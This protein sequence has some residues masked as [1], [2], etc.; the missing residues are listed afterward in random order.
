VGGAGTIATIDVDVKQMPQLQQLRMVSVSDMGENGH[1]SG[2]PYYS[3]GD[4][5]RDKDDCHWICVRP[6]YSPSGKEDTHWMSFQLNENS[7]IKYYRKSNTLF[8]AY[9]VNLGVQKE[10]MQYL[11]QLLTILADP[12]EYVTWAGKKGIPLGGLGE[13]AMSPQELT[14]LAWLWEI[15]YIWNKIAPE[16]E[17]QGDEE[18]FDFSESFTAPVCFIYEK[19]SV[20][21]TKLSIPC[22]EYNGLFYTGIP[23]YTTKTIDMTK[24]S[25]DYKRY[26]LNYST[27]ITQP[28]TFIVRY[29][30]GF[31]LSSNIIFS[32]KATEAIPGVRT[33]FRYKEHKN[34]LD[35]TGISKSNVRVGNVIAKNGRFYKNADEAKKGGG[36]IAV[37]VYAGEK[38][39][40][41]TGTD[42]RGL[43]ISINNIGKNSLAKFNFIENKTMYDVCTTQI[44]ENEKD[45]FRACLNG[46]QQTQILAQG[47]GK[48]HVHPAAYACINDER[49]ISPL[50]RQENGFSD[51]FLPST[52]QW[53]LMAENLLGMRWNGNQFNKPDSEDLLDFF[54]DNAGIYVHFDT[55]Q[56]LFTSTHRDSE[57]CWSMS[58]YSDEVG[59]SSYQDKIFYQTVVPMMAF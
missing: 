55:Y 12:D 3:F 51:W 58:F 56:N 28:D 4:V 29:K 1:F 53:I 59:F 9:P 21:G 45:R 37:V 20:S 47:C 8:Q 52:G 10:K 23:T 16:L 11:A 50:M 22:V 41:E 48:G 46:L 2:E 33:V 49:L 24:N 27:Q 19:G 14:N 25:F 30:T 38:G 57:H 40:V 7:N 54:F 44:G 13:E 26:F 31:Q 35:D 18:T 17:D 42:Y 15:H 32:P 36:A 6:A 39:S 5:V 34:E 43:A